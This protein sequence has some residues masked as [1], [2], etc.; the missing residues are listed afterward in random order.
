MVLVPRV[1]DIAGEASRR[2]P[3]GFGDDR[4]LAAALALGAPGHGFPRSLRTPCIEDG[5]PLV[6][7]PGQPCLAPR[8]CGF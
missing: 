4:G 3:G 2:R 5:E 6:R 8:L 1:V 7:S